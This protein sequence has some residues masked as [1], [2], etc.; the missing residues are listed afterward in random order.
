LSLEKLYTPP[1]VLAVTMAVLRTEI[2]IMN[3]VIRKTLF[4]IYMKKYPPL[5]TNILEFRPLMFK[6]LDI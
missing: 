2:K 1:A 6:Q 5:H 3:A 4:I